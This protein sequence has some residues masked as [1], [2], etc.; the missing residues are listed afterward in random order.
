[1][2]FPQSIHPQSDSLLICIN[3]QLIIPEVFFL[4]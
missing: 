4:E 3:S 1:M 2:A